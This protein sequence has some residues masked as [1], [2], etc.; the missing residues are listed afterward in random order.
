MKNVLPYRLFEAEKALHPSGEEFM[1]ELS[2][3]PYKGILDPWY[4]FTPR[5]TGRVSIEGSYLPSQAYFEKKPNGDWYYIFSASG[6]YYG[7][8]DGDLQDLFGRIIKDSVKK[9]APSYLNKKDIETILADDEWLF[10][11]LESQPKSIYKKISTKL[12][13]ESGIILDFT[14]LELP[15]AKDFENMEFLWR[16]NSEM[17]SVKFIFSGSGTSPFWQIVKAVTGKND[18]SSNLSKIGSVTFYPKGSGVSARSTSKDMKIDIGAKTKEEA[19]DLIQKTLVKYMLKNDLV[20][21]EDITESQEEVIKTLY[22]SIIQSADGDKDESVNP[23]LDSY[24]KK[25]PLDLHILDSLPDVKKGVVQ[26]TGIKD[27]SRLGSILGSN[28]L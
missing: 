20:I 19:T 4:K 3:S 7:R 8:Q 18:P 25:N 9:G 24:F 17:G 12:G 23:F 2:K 5:R 10:S 16:Y 1:S 6:H 26:R 27:L 28:L 14:D 11:N 13:G 15:V 21:R 22:K